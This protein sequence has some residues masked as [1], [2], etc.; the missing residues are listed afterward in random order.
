MYYKLYE[1]SHAAL[2]PNPCAFQRHA[3]AEPLTPKVF[4]LCLV[5][6]GLIEAARSTPISR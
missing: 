4:G 5:R 2:T 3:A 1:M 6:N